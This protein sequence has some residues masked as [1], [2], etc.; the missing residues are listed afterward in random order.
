VV[1]KASSEE[2]KIKIEIPPLPPG[3]ELHLILEV[4]DNGLPSMFGYKR[5]I[6]TAAI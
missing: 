5:V 2:P 3:K 6:I 1:F 4:M